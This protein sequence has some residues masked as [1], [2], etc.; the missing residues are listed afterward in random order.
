MFRVLSCIE[1]AAEWDRLF[2]Q[3]PPE[4]QDVHFTSAYA[5]VQVFDGRPGCGHLAVF[6][7]SEGAII[8]PFRWRPISGGPY[9]DVVNL[10][11]YGGPLMIGDAKPLRSMWHEAWHRWASDNGVVSEFQVIHP[12]LADHQVELL[13]HGPVNLVFT[14]DVVVIE[15]LKQFDLSRVARRVKRAVLKDAGEFNEGRT[16]FTFANLYNQSMD[17]LKALERWRYPDDYFHAHLLEPIDARLF[18]IDKDSRAL[19]TVGHGRTVYAHF[20]GSNGKA[21]GNGLDELLYYNAARQL[22][23]KYDRFHLGGGL[24]TDPGDSLLFFKRGFS[25]RLYRVGTY[26]RVFMPEA[27]SCLVEIKRSHELK[28]HGRE[29]EQRWFPAY[30]REFA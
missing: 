9:S 22:S 11:G 4:L 24:T 14:K 19:L 2:E 10:Y 7:N 30:R 28:Q 15:D 1:D 12:L 13:R 27:Y 6:G 5:R 17:R 20:L 16:W 26:S 25:D 21:Q 3:I 23:E 18:F 29:S 8:L